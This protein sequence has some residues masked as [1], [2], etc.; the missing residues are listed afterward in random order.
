MLNLKYTTGDLVTVKYLGKIISG[1]ITG[2]SASRNPD[3]TYNQSYTVTYK[4][5]ERENTISGI[6]EYDIIQAWRNTWVIIK[7]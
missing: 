7:E 2:L 3:G 1:K 4:D 5:S 6:K